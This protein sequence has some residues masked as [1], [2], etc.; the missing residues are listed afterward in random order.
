MSLIIA[1]IQTEKFNIL[2][3]YQYDLVQLPNSTNR[4]LN[5]IWGNRGLVDIIEVMLVC[6]TIIYKP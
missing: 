1:I 6:L 5:L 4:E 2:S 3:L